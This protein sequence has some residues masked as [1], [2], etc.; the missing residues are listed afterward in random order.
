MNIILP[1]IRKRTYVKITSAVRCGRYFDVRQKRLDVFGV[2]ADFV[3]NWLTEMHHTVILI[4]CINFIY[5]SNIICNYVIGRVPRKS[6]IR[7]TQVHLHR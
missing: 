5:E 6:H 1:Y 2:E 3:D 7:I 4:L